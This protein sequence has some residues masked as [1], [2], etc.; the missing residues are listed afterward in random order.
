MIGKV[1]SAKIRIRIPAVLQ[2]LRAERGRGYGVRPGDRV[3][4][5]PA[6]CAVECPQVF[7]SEQI[8]GGCRKIRGRHGLSARLRE[9]QSLSETVL[10]SFPESFRILVQL[11][12]GILKQ[13]EI[14]ALGSERKIRYN[15]EALQKRYA[16]SGKIVCA[17]SGYIKRQFEDQVRAA[18]QQG[19]SSLFFGYN[20]GG[21][22]LHI[23]AA[24]GDH[25]II[26]ACN[27]SRFLK[28]VLVP[29]VQ[30]V[31]FC[32]NASHFHRRFLPS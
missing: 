8:V 21:A 5:D 9:G 19:G 32:D 14:A 17:G 7:C 30:R 11:P 28:K 16:S 4:T 1:I 29:F 6:A 27:L 24:H 26:G 12:G 23:V 31:A 25:N 13:G 10:Q 2:H 15:A 3:G 18:L 20:G 22:A